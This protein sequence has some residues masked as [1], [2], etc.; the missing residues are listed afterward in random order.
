[1]WGL[2][3]DMELGAS[4][5]VGETIGHSLA[6]AAILLSTER[7]P[8][9][10]IRWA[11]LGCAG[12]VVRQ[13]SAH[14]A[15]KGI[16]SKTRVVAAN[17]RQGLGAIAKGLSHEPDPLDLDTCGSFRWGGTGSGSFVLCPTKGRDPQPQTKYALNRS[18]DGDKKRN[19]AGQSSER[20]VKLC[21]PMNRIFHFVVVSVLL[22]SSISRVWSESVAVTLDENGCMTRRGKPYFVKGAGG[23]THLDV[24]AARGANSLRTWSTNSLA[25]T[26]D[27]AQKL[28]LTVSA[29]IWLESECA[30]FS[31]ANPEHCAKQ[32][33]RV[34]Q[35]ILTFRDH[36][37]LLAWGLGNEAEGD[38]RNAAYWQQLE[39]LALVAKE[40]DPAHPTFTAVAG[41]SADKAV[42]LNKFTP[43]LDYVGINTYGGLFT[44]R[45]HLVDI[46]WTRPW[47]LTEWGPQGFWER[48]KS[49]SGV[50]LEQTSTEKAAMMRRG[51]DEVIAQGGGCLGSYAFVWGW[52]YEATVTWF[53]LL[54]ADGETTAAVDVLEEKWCGRRPSNLAPTIQP[55]KGVPEQRL[56]P[57]ATFSVIAEC[58]DHE[59]D[60]L[61]WRWAVL[62]EKR[63]HNAGEH[64]K[65]PTSINGTITSSEGNRA[66]VR[67]PNKAGV[68]R[69]HVWVSDGHGHAATAN[70]PFEVEPL[71]GEK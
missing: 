61:V 60:P 16:V 46:G 13:P 63:N 47:M 2:R 43:H 55:L 49:K 11:L 44:L 56:K 15:L 64:P 37:A 68:Y 42:G 48:P 30:W 28:G 31:Y 29:G 36:P 4:E 34:Q 23:E 20:A 8:L 52:K 7:H 58:A 27:E 17:D 3:C 12:V 1:M 66:N 67:A 40:I 51:Y 6:Q 39:K 38:G 24:L 71:A 69:L 32:L 62:P 14:P 10:L 53:G 45:Q 54:T 65:M 25:T 19:L 59:G 18:H 26:L 35:E 22:L 9:K 41:L 57:R 50:A 5:V 70:T 21:L 33:K